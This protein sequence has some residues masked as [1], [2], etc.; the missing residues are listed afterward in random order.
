MSF[1]IDGKTWTPQSAGEH[2]N[3]I[4]NRVNAILQAENVTDADGNII[5]L[6]ASYGNA[7]WLLALGDGNRLALNDEKL[8]RGINSFNLEL[9]DDAQIENLLPIAAVTRSLG[10]YSRLVLTVTAADSGDCTVPA[11]TKAPFGDV[12]FVV[13]TDAV[14]PAGTTQEVETVCDT[15]G[16]VVVLTGEVTSFETSIANLESVENLQS[17]IPGTNAETVAELRQ[18]LIKG[19]TIKYS[20]DG[21]KI[22][23]ENLTGVTYARVYFNYK[24]D[25]NITLPGG[26]QVAPRHAFVVVYGTN[27]EIAET[28]CQYMGAETQHGNRAGTKATVNVTITAEESGTF[29]I[30]VPQGT[31]ATWNGVVFETDEDVTLSEGEQKTVGMTA[32]TVGVNE[33][34][35]GGITAFDEPVEGVAS[36]YNEAAG[37]PGT[38]DPRKSQVYVTASGQEVEVLFDEASEQ[39]VFVKIVLKKGESVLDEVAAQLKRDLIAA[40]ANWGIGEQV[41]QLLTSA[42]FTNITYTQVAYTQVSADGATW[43]NSIDAAAD[44]VPRVSDATITVVAEDD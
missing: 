9:C 32:Q 29:P 33:V 44:C 13:K 36:V 30:T 8:E 43:S 35:V 28:Y 27:E 16:A 31:E 6:K 2:A 38:D 4:M 19:D 34:P 24:L 22:A 18:R 37:T 40:S 10:S 26:T 1:E 7:L 21:L 42:P 11:G 17:S 12:N 5:Q 14:I 15:P 39:N 23:L 20:V 25:E 3:A 41:T